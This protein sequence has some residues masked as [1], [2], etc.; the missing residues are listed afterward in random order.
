MTLATKSFKDFK[1]EIKTKNFTGDKIAIDRIINCEIQVHD[2]KIE[3]S[4]YEKGN[5]KCLCLQIVF[6][7]DKRVLFTGSTRL[8]E[9]IEK[10]PVD[11]YPFIATIIK[12]DK[13]FKFT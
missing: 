4:K 13:Q 9:Q 8:M 2:M 5:G 11:G 10:V 6:N 1:I 3:N 12:E 7:G